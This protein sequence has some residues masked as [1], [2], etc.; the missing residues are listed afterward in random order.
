MFKILKNIA[1]LFFRIIQISVLIKV[2]EVKDIYILSL[3]KLVF[4]TKTINLTVTE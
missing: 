3:K 1:K 4:F 2:T